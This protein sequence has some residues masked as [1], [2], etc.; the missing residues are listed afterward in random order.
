MLELF[1][2][3]QKPYNHSYYVHEIWIIDK[4]KLKNDPLQ[5]LVS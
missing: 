5:F 4:L 1:I 2:N 3:K